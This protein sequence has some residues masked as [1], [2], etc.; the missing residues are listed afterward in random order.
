MKYLIK[1]ACPT[2]D[3]LPSTHL[4]HISFAY[5]TRLAPHA[6]VIQLQAF[7]KDD[8][9]MRR[10]EKMSNY[11]YKNILDYNG[12]QHKN[13]ISYLEKPFMTKKVLFA[14]GSEIYNTTATFSMNFSASYLKLIEKLNGNVTLKLANT[15]MIILVEYLMVLSYIYDRVELGKSE[16]DTPFR[17]SFYVVCSGLNQE[18]RDK[19]FHSIKEDLKTINQPLACIFLQDI[20]CA[21]QVSTFFHSI[22]SFIYKLHA[23]V[24]LH[25]SYIRTALNSDKKKQIRSH[26]LWAMLDEIVEKQKYSIDSIQNVLDSF[27]QPIFKN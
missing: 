14:N 21:N 13:V 23:I 17:D 22:K 1:V 3:T 26:H 27:A 9:D 19:F 2:L 20:T 12:K 10:V 8:F 11:F 7:L 24:I 25:I 16:C 5:N 15:T 6:N 4:N 18:K